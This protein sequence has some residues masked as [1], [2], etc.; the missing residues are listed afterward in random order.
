LEAVNSMPPTRPRITA[1]EVFLGYF[2]ACGVA[3]VGVPV[4]IFGFADAPFPAFGAE[5][6]LGMIGAI[7]MLFLVICL[8]AWPGFLAM[9]LLLRLLKWT[10]W[11]SFALAGGLSGML[12]TLL[13]FGPQ[14]SSLELFLKYP[15]SLIF[16]LVGALSGAVACQTEKYF[17]RRYANKAA[18]K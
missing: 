1:K 7:G 13:F 6:V 12:L 16:I 5:A 14:N 10:D 11:P 15:P 4:A 3:A 8:A 17:A 2:L 9:R 18:T